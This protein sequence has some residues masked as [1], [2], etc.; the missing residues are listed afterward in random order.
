MR[1][2]VFCSAFCKGTHEKAMLAGSI[3]RNKIPVAIMA[4]DKTVAFKLPSPTK[5]LKTINA[6]IRIVKDIP[7]IKKTP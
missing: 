6:A 4:M 2:V 3:K 7:I 1:G 5:G